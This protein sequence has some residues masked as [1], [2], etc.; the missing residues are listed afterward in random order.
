P[1]PAATQNE[2]D[3]KSTVAQSTREADQSLDAMRGKMALRISLEKGIEANT[4]LKDALEFLRDRYDVAIAVDSQGF[5][6][7]EKDDIGESGVELPALIHVR[8]GSVLGMLARQVKGICLMS[9]AKI[10]IV[11]DD[12]KIVQA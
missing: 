9:Q 10:V 6:A 7:A 1:Q 8:L 5:E 4:R 3:P 11:P 2:Q 12:E